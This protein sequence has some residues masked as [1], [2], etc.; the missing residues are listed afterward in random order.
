M[1]ESNGIEAHIDPGLKEFLAQY[2]EISIDFVDNVGG[3]GGYL[4]KV[5][6]GGDCGGG[7]SCS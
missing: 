3:K 2:G 5:G 4:V 7:C 6:K 1:L